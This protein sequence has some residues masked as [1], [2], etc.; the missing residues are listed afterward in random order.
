M[1]GDTDYFLEST[2]QVKTDMA[3]GYSNDMAGKSSRND[4]LSQN[5]NYTVFLLDQSKHKEVEKEIGSEIETAN[6]SSHS[7]NRDN[8]SKN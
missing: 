3:T 2:R 5:E 4:K 7:V 6:V 1:G 8:D